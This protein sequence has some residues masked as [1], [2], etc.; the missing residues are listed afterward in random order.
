MKEKLFGPEGEE[1]I[2]ELVG[3]TFAA[4]MDEKSFTNTRLTAI[5][6]LSRGQG[7]E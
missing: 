1:Q 2:A 5:L 7:P 6:D 3:Q 4:P